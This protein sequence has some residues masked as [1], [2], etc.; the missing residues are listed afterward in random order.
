M[1][2]I[3]FVT[4]RIVLDKLG[5]SDYG[6]NNLV[7]GFVS[8]FTILNR[9]L[10]TGTSRFLAL[11]IGKGDAQKLKATFSTAFVIHLIIGLIIV[12]LLET[13]GLW[14]LN[15]QLNIDYFRKSAA[16]WVFQFAVVSTFLSITQTPY[17]AA[18]TSHEKFNIYA[19]M[20]IFDVIAKLLILYLLIV[21][22][23]DKLI[24]YSALLLG[25]YIC[26]LCAYRIY[27]IRHFKECAWSLHVNRSLLKEMVS[28]S[29]WSTLGHVLVTINGQGNSI[30]LNIFFNTIM[31][32]ARG[33]SQTVMFTI[34][35]FIQGFLVAAQPQLIKYYGAGD[36]QRFYR[37]IFNVSQYT[38]FLVAIFMVP[39]LMEVDY[40]V[41]IWLGGNV[42]PYTIAF[43]KITMICTVIYNSNHMV[44]CG[45]T[46]IG[47]VKELNC[48]SIPVYLLTL[49]LSYFSLS[50][51]WSP[52]IMYWFSNIP[53]LL[54]F[55]INL[56]ILSRYTE[57]PGKKY[58]IQ[59]FIKSI[60]LIAVSCIFPLIIQLQMEEGIIRLLAVCSISVL[61]TF[62]VFYFF[63]MNKATRLMIKEKILKRFY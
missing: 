9:I 62:I 46:A 27:C 41:K 45:I 30:I 24:I 11:Y 44:D 19:M 56:W 42:P 40:V 8:M 37:L 52:I 23:G 15:T 61:S 20:S 51:G 34:G 53:P 58:F 50:I 55:L 59:I 10:N 1:M 32:A 6:L 49:P 29:G 25:V 28:F 16:N 47:R 48:W 21:I 39:V 43:I 2:A 60:S 54:A 7:S 36:M 12:V 18:V 4:T 22:P 5:A 35:Q 17:T 57:F 63:G 31:N 13:I 3:S 33:L 14:F 38:L 26:D